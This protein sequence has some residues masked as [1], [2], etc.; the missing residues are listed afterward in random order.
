MIQKSI[1]VN[2]AIRGKELCSLSISNDIG[3]DAKAA[4]LKL[5]VYLDMLIDH[6]RVR[7]GRNLIL[8]YCTGTTINVM[9]KTRCTPF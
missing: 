9:P 3:D 1:V 2:Y 5:E 4:L 6:M 8:K 7:K